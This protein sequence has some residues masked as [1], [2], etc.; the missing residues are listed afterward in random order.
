MKFLI[1]NKL[2]YRVFI[3]AVAQLCAL[4][5]VSQ[6]IS[7]DYVQ[8]TYTFTAVDLAASVDEIE[9]NGIGLSLSLGFAPNFALT[10]GVLDTTFQR[11]QEIDIDT[12]KTTTLGLTA[13]VATSPES[14]L[15]TNLSALKAD[16]AVTDDTALT[17]DNNLGYDASIGVRHLIADKLELELGLSHV[18]VFDKVDNSFKADARLYI[19]KRITLGIGYIAGDNVDSISL[20]LRLDV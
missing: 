7:F 12:V 18:Y 15:F 1:F 17:S 8:A 9:G 19:R 13:H 6:D 3:V 10:F 14:E 4:N 11:Y 5:A 2:L 16:I 20:N